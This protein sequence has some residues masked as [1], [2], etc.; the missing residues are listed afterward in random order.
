MDIK[1]STLE[2]SWY[3][4][5]V[6]III[7]IMLYKV[8]LTLQSVDETLVCDHSNESLLNCKKSQSYLQALQSDLFTD[9]LAYLKCVDN[10][11]KKSGNDF[12]TVW[13]IKIVS[14]MDIKFSTLEKSWYFISV[15]IIIF[16]MLY[17]VVLTLQSV[18]ETLECDH[19]NESY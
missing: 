9:V 17:K 7:F 13:K 18:D 5:S 2:K 8:V 3:F 16:I 14:S 19:S 4:I 10:L 12:F 1:F 15:Y 11:S 6:Y